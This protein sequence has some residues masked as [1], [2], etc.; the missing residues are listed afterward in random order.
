MVYD[1]GCQKGLNYMDL[2]GK[3]RGDA[4]HHIGKAFNGFWDVLEGLLNMWK[5]YN[6]IIVCSSHVYDPSAKKKKVRDHADLGWNSI[7]QGQF[8]TTGKD[9]MY[10]Y[11][12]RN[13]FA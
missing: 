5:Y 7:K 4:C 10:V 13:I 8:E 3:D 6:I 9:S 11:A 2:C 1:K 12:L